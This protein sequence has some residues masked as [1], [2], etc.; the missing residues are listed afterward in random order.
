M[1][2]FLID[3]GELIGLGTLSELQKLSGTRKKRLEDIFLTLTEEK[4][5]G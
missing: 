2:L 3:K 4:Y 5:E 1:K